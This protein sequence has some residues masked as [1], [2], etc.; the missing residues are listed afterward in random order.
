MRDAEQETDQARKLRLYALIALG[1]VALALLSF[2]IAPQGSSVASCKQLF[3]ESS[4]YSC[5]TNLALSQQNAS[6]CG[7]EQGTYKDSCYLQVAE[8]IES[9]G[10]CGSIV[11]SGVMSACVA[12]VALAT[13]NYTACSGAAEP[14]ASNCKE[15]IALRQNSLSMCA[16]I[17][18][19]TDSI[20]CTSVVSTRHAE[21][22]GNASYCGNVTSSQN[23]SFTGLIISK[24]ST[25]ASVG[26]TSQSSFLQ[27]SL[28]LLPNVTYTARDYCYSTLAAQLS[29]PG[30]CANVSAGEA[31]NICTL[32]SGTSTTSNVTENYTTQLAACANVGAY[33]Q[34]CIQSV[35]LTQ[36][37]K[38]RNVTLCAQLQGLLGPT[39]YATLA[40]AY[41]NATYCD[42]ISD[43]TAKSSCVSG[44][45]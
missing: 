43:P 31:A 12:A 38:T 18:N 17:A 39:C 14:V 9:V 2:L 36:A 33:S 32:Q 10:T 16:G 37:V 4:K 1:L 15:T 11:D 42:Y 29:S 35:M 24:L 40:Q 30:L 44:A 7:N 8:K 27:S 5:I 26:A 41:K 25:N 19:L 20:V 13:N 28:F 45:S 23:K 22:S 21:Q 6:M 3:F 34:A